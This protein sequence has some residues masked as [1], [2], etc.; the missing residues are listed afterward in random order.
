MNS[1]VQSFLQE[2]LQVKKAEANEVVYSFTRF[3]NNLIKI[4][5]LRITRAAKFF[6]GFVLNGYSNLASAKKQ[7]DKKLVWLLRA[8]SVII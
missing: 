6:C 4:I 7:H 3:L 8:K 5:F 1:A 2:P